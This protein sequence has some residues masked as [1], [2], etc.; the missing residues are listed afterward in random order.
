MLAFPADAGRD[1]TGIDLGLTLSLIPD[2]RGRSAQLGRASWYGVC[3]LL[4][5]IFL[6]FPN[7]VTKTSTIGGLCGTL[8]PTGNLGPKSAFVVS[9]QTSPIGLYLTTLFRGS[10]LRD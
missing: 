7:F 6:E 5:R 4:T 2:L 3:G 9:R 1:R 8:D 10:R